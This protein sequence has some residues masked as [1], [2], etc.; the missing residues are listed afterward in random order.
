M[1]AGLSSAATMIPRC[2][3]QCGPGWATASPGCSGDEAIW[4][5]YAALVLCAQPSVR[6]LGPV[7]LVTADGLVPLAGSLPRGLLAVVA[8]E[9]PRPVSVDRLSALLW[10]DDAPAGVK[11]ALQQIASRLRRS[12]EAAGMAGALRAVP[13]GYA[14][15]IDAGAIDVRVFRA[16]VRAGCEARRIGDHDA[17]ATEF[18]RGLELW[19]GAAFADLVD[20]PLATVLA[21]GLDEERWKTEELRAEALLAAGRPGDVATLLSAV[22]SEAPLRERLWVLQAQALAASGHPADAIRCV[23]AGIAVIAAELGVPPGPELASLEETLRRQPVVVP[24][25]GGA[26]IV[27]SAAHNGLLDAAL[28]RALANAESAAVAAGARLGHDEAVRQWQ[29]ALELLDSVD[30][31]DDAHRLRLLLGLGEAH[32]TASLDAEAREVFLEA[33]SVAHRLGDAPGLAWAT[34]GYCSDRTSFAPPPQQTQMLTE[35]LDGLEPG[36]SLLRGRLLGRL[37]TEQYWVGSV[38]RTYELAQAAMREAEAAGDDAGRLLAHYA[39][40]F[41]CWTPDRTVQLVEVCE[42]Y[43][44]DARRAGDHRHELLAHRWLVPAVV[45]LGDVDRGWREAQTAMEM[46]EELGLSVQQWVSRVIAASTLLIVGDLERAEELATEGLALGSVSEPEVALDF[47]SL[48]MWTLRWL[49]GRLAEIAPL[50]EQAAFGPGVD[51][52]RRLGLALTHAELGRI[53]DARRILDDISADDVDA[54]QKN[55]SWYISMAAMAEAAALTDHREAATVVFDRLRPHWDRIAIT[56]VTATGPI[57]HHVGISAW[58]AGHREVALHMLGEAVEIAD[59]VG[60]PVFGARSQLAL[61]ERLTAIG[62]VEPAWALARR[63][64]AT[65]VRLGLL[66]IE[67]R[68]GR[69]YPRVLL[70]STSPPRRQ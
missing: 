3:E 20:L 38:E 41:G 50:V 48:F 40:A 9:S 15:E 8:L 70:T 57:A 21:P 14:L 43:L 25:S 56:S 52:A 19:R 67:E 17:A 18:S 6:V 49:Q 35:A 60:A 29:R 36:E 69:L 58:T 5:V 65:A 64:H 55:T 24:P 23:R 32:N 66:G 59:R 13:P 42:T 10:G 34:L 2:K 46:A 30:P 47:V 16:A 1:A 63:A 53:V 12:L 27:V 61:A 62:E 7:A 54:M 11:A 22:T 44:D 39:M 28:R 33:M 51:L 37:A 31:A 68:A 26:S 4:P 45:E